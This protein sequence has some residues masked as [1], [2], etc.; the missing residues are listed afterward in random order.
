MIRGAVNA[1]R[2]AKIQF[3]ILGPAEER[4]ETTT[5]IEVI[6]G[7]GFAGSLTPLSVIRGF[8]PQ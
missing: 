3:F 4:S 5:E 8:A 6:I 7:E 2:E 1:S